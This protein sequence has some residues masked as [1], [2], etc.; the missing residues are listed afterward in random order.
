M[1]IKTEFENVPLE[2]TVQKYCWKCDYCNKLYATKFSRDSHVKRIHTAI[3][4]SLCIEVFTS[5]N[6]FIKHHNSQHSIDVK[7]LCTRPDDIVV[8]SNSNREHPELSSGR[9]DLNQLTGTSGF[10]MKKENNDDTQSKGELFENILL[11]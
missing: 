5:M 9:H 7:N 4:C 11:N 6:L 2:L 1:N 3:V 8:N 10:S